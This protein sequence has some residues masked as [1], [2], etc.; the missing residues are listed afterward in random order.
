M[1]KW[2]FFI[3]TAL[4]TLGLSC[5]KERSP[6]SIKKNGN[7]V[8]EFSIHEP[9]LNLE[10]FCGNTISSFPGRVSGMICPAAYGVADVKYLFVRSEIF[11]GA[12]IEPPDS[13]RI[14][15]SMPKQFTVT[16]EDGSD[17]TFWV[18]IG[19]VGGYW[20][21]DGEVVDTIKFNLKYPG[22]WNCGKSSVSPG[23]FVFKIGRNLEDQIAFVVDDWD[24]MDWTVLPK[25][26][27]VLPLVIYRNIP[28]GSYGGFEC[29]LCLFTITDLDRER[30][31]IS[32]NWNFTY[33][34]DLVNG[35]VGTFSHVPLYGDF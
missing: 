21:K 14:D 12:T 5:E 11:T 35:S 3:I 20:L 26:I 19:T 6:V 31:T 27:N 4:A 2:P 9:Q 1:V 28:F 29:D 23:S 10:I 24:N 13:S 22:D 15:F 7:K 18:T 8:F 25:S 16:A 34:G 32:G 33:Q 17:T 30:G